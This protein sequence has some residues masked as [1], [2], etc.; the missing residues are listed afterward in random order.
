MYSDNPDLYLHTI[1]SLEQQMLYS[2]ERCFLWLGEKLG[3]NTP[4]PVWSGAGVWR[5]ALLRAGNGEMAKL[6]L[7]KS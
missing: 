4:N 1:Q 5:E 3:F 7:N 2:W 6:K